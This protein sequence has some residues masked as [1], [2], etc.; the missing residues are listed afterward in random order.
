MAR[1]RSLQCDRT[2][3]ANASPMEP[4]PRG[5]FAERPRRTA[6]GC[7]GDGAEPAWG[8]GARRP[9]EGSVPIGGA[10]ARAPTAVGG[11]PALAAARILTGRVPIGG[12]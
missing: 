9:I 11:T 1:E 7:L 4:D 6:P 10:V 12:R 8:S 5:G 3:G 2:H